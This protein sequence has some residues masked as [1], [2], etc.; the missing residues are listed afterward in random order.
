MNTENVSDMS[1]M[2]NNCSSLLNLPDIS[3]WNTE[4][5]KDISHMF[6]NCELLTS[7]PDISEWNTKNIEKMEETFNNCKSLSSLPNLSKWNIIEG[8]V[9]RNIFEGCKLLEENFKDNNYNYKKL[10]KCFGYFFCICQNIVY[11]IINITIFFLLLF[12]PSKYFILLYSSFYLDEINEIISFPIE[13][14]NL[15]EHT[16][17][18]CITEILN[19]NNVT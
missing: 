5:V 14:L 2:F 13:K 10:M 9:D 11:L 4:K 19:I 17:I 6:Q 1:Y 16:N 3:K 15:I 18:T 8:I 7:L 12:F